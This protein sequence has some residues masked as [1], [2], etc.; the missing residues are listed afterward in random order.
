[1]LERNLI[2]QLS[3]AAAEIGRLEFV[4]GQLSR[5]DRVSDKKEQQIGSGVHILGHNYYET[6]VAVGQ[7]RRYC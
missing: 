4:I 5:S 1:L 2:R 3:G 6:L 7:H